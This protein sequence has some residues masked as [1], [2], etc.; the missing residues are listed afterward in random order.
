MRMT[1]RVANRG[2]ADH[3]A[4]KDYAPG[5]PRIAVGLAGQFRAVQNRSQGRAAQHEANHI[6]W[7]AL[8]AAQVRNKHGDGNQRTDTERHVSQE[9]TAPRRLSSDETGK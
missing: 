1:R 9:D 2:E 6:E 5:N 7:L 3:Q 8:S 4:G